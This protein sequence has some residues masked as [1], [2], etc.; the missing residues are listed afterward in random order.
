MNI[1]LRKIS[2]SARLSEETP[3]YT[4]EIW[5]DG[6]KRGATKNDGRGGMDIIHPHEL[7]TALE[8]HAK[9]LPPLV[10][11]GESYTQDA[12]MVLHGLLARHSEGHRLRRMLKCKVVFVHDGQVWSG[13][14]RPG[15]G[16]QGAIVL[17]DLP[18][19]KALDLFLG[20]V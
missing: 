20:E 10:V 7:R 6:I 12:D 15:P 18:F 4:A 11:G 13:T 16:R 8:A 19:D 2:H 3:A 9:T 17:N 1:E 5:I 14:G